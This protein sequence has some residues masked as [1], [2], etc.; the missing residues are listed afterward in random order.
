MSNVMVW[1]VTY[2]IMVCLFFILFVDWQYVC[3]ICRNNEENT[4]Y[5]IV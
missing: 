1:T 5:V 2:V 4:D 3:P